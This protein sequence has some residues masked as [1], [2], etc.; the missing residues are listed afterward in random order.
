MSD[1]ADD[2]R[3]RIE[4]TIG[5]WLA[6][7][8]GGMVTGFAAVINYFDADGDSSWATA[9]SDEQS[10]THTL[11]LLRWHTMA[12]EH[13]VSAYFHSEDFGDE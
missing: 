10:P 2:L 12:V 1:L 13:E 5:E 7:H 4:T 6:T 9:H 11:G 8:G 3:D